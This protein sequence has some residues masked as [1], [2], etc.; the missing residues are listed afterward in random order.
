MD[1]EFVRSS[2]VGPGYADTKTVPDTELGTDHSIVAEDRY[3]GRCANH[4][5]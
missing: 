5:E 2:S 3:P 4:V 1:R